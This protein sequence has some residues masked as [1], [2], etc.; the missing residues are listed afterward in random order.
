MKSL[1]RLAAD[2]VV[3]NTQELAQLSAALESQTPTTPQRGRSV[4]KK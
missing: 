1:G 2:E 3:D 4:I